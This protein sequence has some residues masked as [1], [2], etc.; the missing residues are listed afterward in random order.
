M[1]KNQHNGRTDQRK[2]A[3]KR[4]RDAQKL[5]NTDGPHLRCSMYIAGYAIECKLKAIAMEIHEVWTLSELAEKQKVS[6]ND[7][8]THGLEA[9]ASNLPLWYN[10]QKSDV[11]WDFVKHVNHWKVSWR[12]NPNEP[13]REDAESFM[14]AIERVYKWLD[15]NRC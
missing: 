7:I 13:T 1:A 10:L 15:S 6:E 14:N 5:Y 4:L 8:Y 12:Y 3:L 2:S 11:W 9:L